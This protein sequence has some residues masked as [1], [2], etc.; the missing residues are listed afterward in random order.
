MEYFF[1]GFVPLR[2]WLGPVGTLTQ[3][4]RVTNINISKMYNAPPLY[5]KG[6]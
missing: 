3:M 5:Q 4:R 6:S 2:N 1:Q